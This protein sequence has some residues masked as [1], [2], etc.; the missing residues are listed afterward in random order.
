MSAGSLHVLI[1][2]AALA[3]PDPFDDTTLRWCFCFVNAV[4]AVAYYCC[5]AYSYQFGADIF[6][7]KLL[8]GYI[9]TLNASIHLGIL[10]YIGTT[11]N[12]S[13][14]QRGIHIHTQCTMRACCVPD[15]T[16]NSVDR[17]VTSMPRQHT[18]CIRYLTHG[19]QCR[20]RCPDNTW[21]IL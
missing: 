7:M 18:P 10:I 12:I 4:F 20:R 16:M 1:L 14:T 13:F 19:R 21:V 15:L 3:L 6:A 5:G 2:V 11:I 8:M 9:S 17:E